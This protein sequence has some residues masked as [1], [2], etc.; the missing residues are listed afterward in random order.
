L[1]AQLINRECLLL[2]R[3]PGST[4][5]LGNVIQTDDAVETVV[6]L[7]QRRTDEHD[8]TVSDTDWVAFFLPTEDVRSG[9]AVLV[10]GFKYEVVGDPWEARNPRTQAASHIEA[11]LRR[12][13]GS[14]DAS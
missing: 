5:E 12:T 13:A 8:N 2:R 7:Q 3:V 4:D 6:E 1:L 9:D 11:G 10:D 14:E